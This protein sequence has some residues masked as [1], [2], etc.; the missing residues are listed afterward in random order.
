[1]VRTMM[2]NYAAHSSS[3]RGRFV[4][5]ATKSTVQMN[6]SVL[7]AVRFL[8]WPTL[9]YIQYIYFKF[10]KHS[11]QTIALSSLKWISKNAFRKLLEAA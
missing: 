6:S 3:N 7:H 5:N 9:S 4:A 8:E 10:Y 2:Q 11:L 1:M